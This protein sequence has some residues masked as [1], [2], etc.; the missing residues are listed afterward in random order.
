MLQESA[1]EEACDSGADIHL[2]W[3]LA[4]PSGNGQAPLHPL[5]LSFSDTN[6]L[7]ELLALR[8]GHFTHTQTD[9][10]EMLSAG[11]LLELSLPKNRSKSCQKGLFSSEE[12]HGLRPP[13]KDMIMKTHFPSSTLRIS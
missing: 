12:S 1:A 6:A 10:E 9:Q 3:Y 4:S 7:R 8:G 11:R 5:R 2:T 13:K